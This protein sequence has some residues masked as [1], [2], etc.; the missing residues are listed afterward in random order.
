MITSL[1]A[2]LRKVQAFAERYAEALTSADPRFGLSV[3]AML[4]DDGC[5]FFVNAF[6]LVVVA[7]EGRRW[8]VVIPEHDDVWVVAMSDVTN[9]YVFEQREYEELVLPEDP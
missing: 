8:L 4:E 7:S 2:P 9:F 6:A 5:R 1:S 3:M